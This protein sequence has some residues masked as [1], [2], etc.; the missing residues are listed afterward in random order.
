MLCGGSVSF[1]T[2]LDHGLAGRT[3]ILFAL[4]N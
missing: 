4:V 2:P 3:T 1:N